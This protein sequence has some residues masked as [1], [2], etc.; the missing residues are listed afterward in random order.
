MD[1]GCGTGVLLEEASQHAQR[2]YGVDPVLEPAQL[3][4]DE[5]KLDKVTLLTPVQAAEEI[6][7]KS[8]D[9]ILAAEV[10]EHIDPLEPTLTFFRSR[11]KPE[12][13]LLVSL[14]TENTLYRLGRRLSR[15]RG[16]Y[17]HSSAVAIH[18][19]I[20]KS[21]FRTDRLQKIPAPGPLSIYW[22]VTYRLEKKPP[23]EK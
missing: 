5:W 14:P 18:Q 23:I 12:G 17:H 4:V 1:F 8:L 20:T 6:P 16:E 10:L 15:F 9:I 13:K 22:V 19:S 7:G 3:L 11:L 21:G 2:V